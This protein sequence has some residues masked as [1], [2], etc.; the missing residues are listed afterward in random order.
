MVVGSSP[1]PLGDFLARLV[2]LGLAV[3]NNETNSPIV[4]FFSS[5]IGGVDGTR[6]GLMEQ[7]MEYQQKLMED[8]HVSSGLLV[9]GWCFMFHL[10]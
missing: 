5:S 2:L 7:E 4:G 10:K 8:T 9:S 1:T 3:E 6:F